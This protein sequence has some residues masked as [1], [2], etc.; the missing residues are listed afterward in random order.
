MEHRETPRILPQPSLSLATG[1]QALI[2][3]QIPKKREYREVMCVQ[4][5]QK[6]SQNGR[7]LNALG[8]AP[9]SEVAAFPGL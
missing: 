1:N 9:S 7:S 3:P 4:A 5:Q 2:R 8:A 6:L